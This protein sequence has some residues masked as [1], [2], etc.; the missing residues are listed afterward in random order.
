MLK[1]G[2]FFHCSDILLDY[3]QNLFINNIKA[4]YA[5][6]IELALF[7][8]FITRIAE[9]LLVKDIPESSANHYPSLLSG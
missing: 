1:L 7:L 4:V 3:K 2:C 6:F 5:L 9:L 8:S